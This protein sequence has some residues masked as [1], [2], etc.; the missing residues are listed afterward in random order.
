MNERS[1]HVERDA[2]AQ[3]HA[4]RHTIREHKL[5]IVYQRSGTELH[6]IEHC[7]KEGRETEVLGGVY[8]GKR[9]R[10]LEPQQCVCILEGDEHPVSATRAHR[11]ILLAMRH[12]DQPLG[13][14]CGEIT[15][16]LLGSIATIVGTANADTHELHSA[17][18]EDSRAFSGFERTA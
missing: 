10:R 14:A 4:V 11:A 1:N 13:F 15:V 8:D 9:W 12:G 17:A 2:H 6:S 18:A 7:A 5:A 3:R 16:P